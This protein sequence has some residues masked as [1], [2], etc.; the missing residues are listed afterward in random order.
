M[1]FDSFSLI[2]TC[3]CLLLAHTLCRLYLY[4]FDSPTQV[5]HL[6]TFL[7]LSI[8]PQSL[9]MLYMT[10]LQNPHLYIDT[11]TGA[12]HIIF[13]LF[14][15]ITAISTIG[16]V[17]NEQTARFLLDY[18]ALF[19]QSSNEEDYGSPEL[20]GGSGKAVQISSTS[21]PNSA[22]T[23]S[24]S[25]MLPSISGASTAQRRKSVAGSKEKSEKEIQANQME[26]RRLKGD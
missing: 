3:S 19:N 26:L 9:I 20:I 12:I 18:D 5:P 11:I 16:T 13:L 21:V 22:R 10:F 17:S 1:G 23:G 8:F 25:V 2:G 24:Q 6:A 14:E 4:V 7:F 15:I